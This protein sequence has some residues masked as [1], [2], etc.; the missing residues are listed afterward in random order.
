[1]E[2]GRGA[3]ALGPGTDPEKTTTEISE[4]GSMLVLIVET[5]G[6]N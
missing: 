5:N 4:G 2:L 6:S 3:V 1:M